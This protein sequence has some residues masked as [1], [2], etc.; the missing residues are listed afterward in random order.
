[1]PELP[2]VEVVCQGLRPSLI[3]RSIRSIWYSG[4]KLRHPFDID[5]IKRHLSGQEITKITRRGRYLIIHFPECFLVIH[6]GMSGNLGLFHKNSP[7]AKHTHITF[8]LDNQMEVRFRDARRFGSIQFFSEPSF[9]I[10]EKNVFGQMGPEPFSHKCSPEYLYQMAIGKSRT[11]K[12]FIMDNHILV[13]VGNIYA[14]E[15]LFKA[16]IN[17]QRPAKSLTFK[18]WKTLQKSVVETLNWAIKCGGSTISDFI[19]ASGE[20]GYFQANFK[21][22]GK[23]GCPC[24]KCGQTIHR[25]KIGGRSSFYC[26]NCQK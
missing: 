15:S 4:Q 8:L 19:N 25:E 6:L 21:V 11:I 7:K 18:E 26:R 24:P 10:L 12:N 20:D 23:P 17:P 16:G 3:N 2:E 13:G 14:N 9:S 22:Y 1:M 5:L